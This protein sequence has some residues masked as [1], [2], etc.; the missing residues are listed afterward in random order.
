MTI[1]ATAAEVTAGEKWGLS[2]QR[3]CLIW[4]AEHSTWQ[5]SVPDSV[6]GWDTGHPSQWIWIRWFCPRTIAHQDNHTCGDV[7]RVS[8]V[9]KWHCVRPVLPCSVRA[10]RNISNEPSFTT[11]PK[12]GSACPQTH[13]SR[14]KSSYRKKCNGLSASLTTYSPRDL[15]REPLST[16]ALELICSSAFPQ[17]DRQRSG[18]HGEQECQS[19]ARAGTHRAHDINDRGQSGLVLGVVEPRLFTD[20]G[21]QLVQVDSGTELLVSL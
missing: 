2:G 9:D 15:S 12:E 17:W 14:R 6:A 21:P 19:W 3:R 1:N 5:S 16:K 13:T 20:Q 8:R 10:L 18:T 4:E 11:Y 7:T